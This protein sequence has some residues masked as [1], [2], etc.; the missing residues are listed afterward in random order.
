MCYDMFDLFLDV[1]ST[2]FSEAL[3]GQTFLTLLGLPITNYLPLVVLAVAVL[4]C[5]NA[6]PKLLARLGFGIQEA[7]LA[8]P[9]D[10]RKAL[11]HF[12]QRLVDEE[13]RV[14]DYF[15]AADNTELRAARQELHY[16]VTEN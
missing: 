12:T 5:T 3:G 13:D 2:A 4:T 15:R 11:T 6:F 7:A 14:L 16:F 9:L 1:E 8:K 10:I